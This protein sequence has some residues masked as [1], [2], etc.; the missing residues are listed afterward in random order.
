MSIWELCS[1]DAVEERIRRL[2]VW[3]V[4][5][6]AKNSSSY[7]L[8]AS[9]SPRVPTAL[10]SIGPRLQ[11]TQRHDA[12][13]PILCGE[14]AAPAD[15]QLAAP[16]PN[17][18]HAPLAADEELAVARQPEDEDARAR[19]NINTRETAAIDN[20][21]CVC[22]ET[23]AVWYVLVAHRQRR[24]SIGSSIEALYTNENVQLTP[25]PS[26]CEI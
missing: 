7:H 1:R 15:G 24:E 2:L 23:R 8:R 21:D 26:A 22:V 10:R 19:K 20:A 18:A 14:H 6:R 5:A 13:H 11:T 25:S 17:G 12:V 16:Q 9:P 3:L 4:H